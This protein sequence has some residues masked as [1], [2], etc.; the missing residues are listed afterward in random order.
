MLY[1]WQMAGM[2]GTY[3]PYVHRVMA[4]R[5]DESRTKSGLAGDSNVMQ[6]FMGFRPRNSV[7]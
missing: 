3:K 4:K 2:M 6:K 1:L 7:F 5:H